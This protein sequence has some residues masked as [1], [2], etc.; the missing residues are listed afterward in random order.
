M[1]LILDTRN[2][3]TRKEAYCHF[4][5]ISKARLMASLQAIATTTIFTPLFPT[6]ALILPYFTPP[7]LYFLHLHY[8]FNL[9]REFIINLFLS[10]LPK[11]QAY[12]KFQVEINFLVIKVQLFP[13]YQHLKG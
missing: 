5:K 11:N 6:S 12:L 9:L 10:I 3:A 1:N 2:V 8:F 13:I 4:F 7:L